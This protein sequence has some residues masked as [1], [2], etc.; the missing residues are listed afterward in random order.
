MKNQEIREKAIQTYNAIKNGKI[1]G[2][3]IATT[4][5]LKIGSITVIL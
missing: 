4:K 2:V 5:T 3:K 1:E